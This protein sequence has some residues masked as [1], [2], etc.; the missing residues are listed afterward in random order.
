MLCSAPCFSRPSVLPLSDHHRQVSNKMGA[1]TSRD[2]DLM[3]ATHPL[4][5]S[6]LGTRPSMDSHRP[7]LDEATLG[8]RPHDPPLPPHPHDISVVQYRSPVQRSGI[9]A[10]VVN[11]DKTTI[12]VERAP[13]NS[14]VL[15]LQFNFS[16]SVPGYIAVYYGARQIIHR[17][18]DADGA[19][20]PVRRVSYKTRASAEMDYNEEDVVPRKNR[21]TEKT[22]FCAGFAMRYQQKR[23]RG[24]N[25]DDFDECQLTDAVDGYYP[26]VIRIEASH[27]PDS[28][29][30]RRMRVVSQSTFAVLTCVGTNGDWGIKVVRQE[31]L[32]AGTI[33]VLQELYGI[34]AV[35]VTASRGSPETEAQGE[36]NVFSVDAS[37]ECV[38]CLTEPCD[39]AVL[40][41]NHM[42]LCQDCGAKLSADP[43]QDRRRCP[44][45]RTDLESLL[46]IVP[47]TLGS[48]KNAGNKSKQLG[49][50]SE[51]C[52]DL[53]LNGDQS[54][55]NDRR[56]AN[57]SQD[58][59]SSLNDEQRTGN[60]SRGEIESIDNTNEGRE[61]REETRME[62]ASEEN[63]SNCNQLSIEQGN[64][65][66]AAHAHNSNTDIEDV[67]AEAVVQVVDFVADNRD[68]NAS[69]R[70]RDER[71]ESSGS[72]KSTAVEGSV[73]KS[74][75]VQLDADDTV[76]PH[77]ECETAEC[78]AGVEST[79]MSSDISEVTSREEDGAVTVLSTESLSLINVDENEDEQTRKSDTQRKI[80][81]VAQVARG[82]TSG[83]GAKNLT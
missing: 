40:P 33:Y 71:D 13:E 18:S 44:I 34:G 43:S 9:V 19:A 45:C 73:S 5:L 29:V 32:V 50:D 74:V 66:D 21:T 81:E 10:N 1:A 4:R 49:Q 36:K 20:S 15:L 83:S 30:P 11:L 7:L 28:S 61:V 63:V 16:A 65:I 56:C 22:K 48:D 68:L 64:T 35:D 6:R 69:D 42:C 54:T 27:S 12:R 47:T 57:T 2:G 59:N 77:A 78:Y 51:A 26:V 75:E 23:A 8:D 3:S 82:S 55:G 14:R 38:I 17:A 41:C 76:S 79:S 24:L 52:A 37:N 70:L 58:T 62:G 31:V 67:I 46:R 72:V 60:D 53:S 80:M 39:T 25:L